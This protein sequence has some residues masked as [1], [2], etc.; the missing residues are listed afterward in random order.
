MKAIVG[1]FLALLMAL[2]GGISLSQSQPTEGAGKIILV[3]DVEGY[4]AI[5]DKDTAR[6]KD[7]AVRDAYRYA[8][9][10]GVGVHIEAET[11]VERFQIVKDQ[12]IAKAVGYVKKLQIESQGPVDEELYKVSGWAR[13]MKGEMPKD[14]W[15]SLKLLIKMMGN[16][17][18]VLMIDE[19]IAGALQPL[20]VIEGKLKTN[21]KEG[22]YKLVEEPQMKLMRQ[23]L[24][25]GLE[26]G[27]FALMDIETA[28]ILVEQASKM[29]AETIIFGQ[30]SADI[31]G[32][33]PGRF[34]LV[35]ARAKGHIDAVMVETGQ[36]VYSINLESKTAA[37]GNT[38]EAAG[39]KAIDA[40]TAQL[41]DFPWKL[42]EKI[43][44]WFTIKLV[45]RGCSYEQAN[46]IKK[47][48]SKMRF[49]LDISDPDI[50]EPTAEF[51]VKTSGNTRD[52]VAR[53]QKVMQFRVKRIGMGVIEVE[54]VSLKI[55]GTM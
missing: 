46:E 40:L 51:E 22:G 18:I 10:K 50:D 33:I 52:L 7:E 24:R 43:K 6:A 42:A 26:S 49:V 32:E 35:T 39:R 16:P 12:I 53:L 54:L 19:Y 27:S 13:V 36:I 3:N 23:A 48:V 20:S 8:I 55:K 21:L 31:T 47:L 17:R 1:S 25:K 2:M 34:P 44:E 41:D 5:F 9:E 28:S 4:G 37:R 45:V 14:D 15:D 38:R 11:E 30:F 29:K